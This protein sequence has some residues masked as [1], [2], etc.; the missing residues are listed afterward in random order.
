MSENFE[1][2]RGDAL[3]EDAK[4]KRLMATNDRRR[5]S[6]GVILKAAADGTFTLRGLATSGAV[7]RMGDV[8]EPSG[9]SAELP[10]P[11]LLGHDHAK[12]IGKVIKATRVAAGVEI[13]ATLFKGA[14]P[15]ID[16]AIKLIQLGLFPGLSIG[17]RSLDSERIPTGRRF[18]KWELLE[19]SAVTV[20][21][22]PEG[23]ITAAKRYGN[24]ERA[25]TSKQVRAWL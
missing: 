24:V 4:L 25:D 2:L 12:P 23:K 21:A 11:F 16:E 14:S 22:N 17:F 19:I 6:A 7:D 10:V 18:K 5:N 13:V 8:V 9:M 3:I 20:P 15:R 1:V